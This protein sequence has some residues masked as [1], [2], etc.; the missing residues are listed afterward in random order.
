MSRRTPTQKQALGSLSN[1]NHGH[2]PACFS[3]HLNSLDTFAV[4]LCMPVLPPHSQAPRPSARVRQIH[5]EFLRQEPVSSRQQSRG[6]S[7]R[8]SRLNQCTLEENLCMSTAADSLV[9]VHLCQEVDHDER[10]GIEGQSLLSLLSLLPSHH[11]N[12]LPVFEGLHL[13]DFLLLRRVS[14]H[15][16]EGEFIKRFETATPSIFVRASFI[17][18]P[19]VG[20]LNLSFHQSVREGIVHV[21]QHGEQLLVVGELLL[22]VGLIQHDISLLDRHELLPFVV[23]QFLDARHIKVAVTSVLHVLS[24]WRS[25]ALGISPS[26][27]WNCQTRIASMALRHQTCQWCA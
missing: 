27:R 26:S 14:D 2:V 16:D 17:S 7:D 15:L 4:T 21:L 3:Q 10:V 6:I 23:N 13:H 24:F 18:P 1:N 22:V 9:S 8:V 20:S 12:V 25:E 19:S 5:A 11:L